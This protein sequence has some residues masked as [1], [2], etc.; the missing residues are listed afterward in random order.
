M[1]KINNREEKKDIYRKRKSV[2]YLKKK[3]VRKERREEDG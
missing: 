2:Q 1:T 3:E